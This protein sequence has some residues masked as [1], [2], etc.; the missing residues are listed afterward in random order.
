M[1][2]TESLTSRPPRQARSKGDVAFSIA[3]VVWWIVTVAGLAVMPWIADFFVTMFTNAWP[4][5]V[6]IMVLW[7]TVPILATIMVIRRFRTG[8]S[9]GALRLMPLPI[10]A[11]ALWLFSADIA[12]LWRFHVERS[13]MM[14]TIAAKRPPGDEAFL[15]YFRWHGVAD[16]ERGV[17][18]DES[19]EIGKPIAQRSAKWKQLAAGKCFDQ[20]KPL[21]GHF[22][23]V[24]VS[25][26]CS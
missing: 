7:S 12:T 6:I 25:I 3:V 24:R 21:G 16:R 20:G 14:E 15:Y 4:A 10:A 18:F 8:D 2:P 23:L 11:V 1:P 5:L 22:Y 26:R 13:A 19:D 17:L 9:S